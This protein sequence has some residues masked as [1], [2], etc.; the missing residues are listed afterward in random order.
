MNPVCVP[1]QWSLDKKWHC[2]VNH[3]SLNL[4]DMAKSRLWTLKSQMLS[5]YFK[6]LESFVTKITMKSSSSCPV[7]YSCVYSFVYLCVYINDFH[8]PLQ[9][10]ENPIILIPA[11]QYVQCTLYC[12]SLEMLHCWCIYR[13]FSCQIYSLSRKISLHKFIHCSDIND[14][15]N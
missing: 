6:A 14:S 5:T 13:D 1:V 8:N 7:S 4:S 3:Q 15:L 11:K 10:C 2:L 12:V 9:R